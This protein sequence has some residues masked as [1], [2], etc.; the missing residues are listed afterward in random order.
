MLEPGGKMLIG[1]IS[2]V[3]RK[4][5]FQASKYGQ[6]FEKNWTVTNQSESNVDRGKLL[7]EDDRIEFSDELVCSLLLHVRRKGYDSFVLG[8]RPDL[9]WGHTREDIV[10]EARH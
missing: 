6:E 8:Q 1:D 3:D 5:R 9:P 4:V 10:I 7:P 2:N